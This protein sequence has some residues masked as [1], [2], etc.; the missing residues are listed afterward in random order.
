MGVL[1]LGGTSRR[2]RYYWGA[3]AILPHALNPL[4]PNSCSQRRIPHRPALTPAL[5]CRQ[6]L[7]GFP[8]S[9]ASPCP[10]WINSA[11]GWAASGW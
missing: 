4:H 10:A 5:L 7:K 1:K 3:A 8:K 6:T 11:G 2:C 9:G